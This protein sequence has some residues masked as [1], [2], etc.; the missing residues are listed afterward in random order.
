MI[1]STSSARRYRACTKVLGCPSD[2]LQVVCFRGVTL[3]NGT[4]G[5]TSRLACFAGRWEWD[6]RANQGT[7]R[8]PTG[9]QGLARP[10]DVRMAQIPA[11]VGRQGHGLEGQANPTDFIAVLV[12][13]R[14]QTRVGFPR[15]W[16]H[17]RGDASLW[18]EVKALEA[19]QGFWQ[20]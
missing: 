2:L 8:G 15:H 14:H 10:A 20:S 16:R 17:M 11:G 6:R 19:S 1:S 5:V 9:G 3:G 7:A 12:N 18:P 4:P 13:G